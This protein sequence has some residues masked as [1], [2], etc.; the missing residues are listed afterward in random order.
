MM[1]GEMEWAGVLLDQ[2]DEDVMRRVARLTKEQM[3]FV[4]DGFCFT[5]I[6]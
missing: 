1:V 6:L 2:K 5:V 3:C 4:V